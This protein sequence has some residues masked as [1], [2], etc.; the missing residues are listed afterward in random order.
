[1]QSSALT[2]LWCYIQLQKFL[3]GVDLH[4]EQI[5]H[6]HNFFNLT[7]RVSLNTAISLGQSQ[8]S[9]FLVKAKAHGDTNF[10][11]ERETGEP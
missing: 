5:R 4:R 1:M 3:I 2:L 7:E 9:S 11:T 6:L 10:S 8:N